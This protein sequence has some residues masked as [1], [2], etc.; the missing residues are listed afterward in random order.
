M[1]KRVKSF[2][3]YLTIECFRVA[4]TGISALGLYGSYGRVRNLSPVQDAVRCLSLK[5]R[6]TKKG[7]LPVTT[8][9]LTDEFSIQTAPLLFLLA[10]SNNFSTEF[11]I[12]NKQSVNKHI[13][14]VSCLTKDFCI[15]HC[16][17]DSCKF[18]FFFYINNK[19]ASYSGT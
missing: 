13:C 9:T 14:S 15:K 11:S 18:M 10:F 4:Q 16:L 8:L 17:N 3:V 12:S 5:K 1:N 6:K 19:N 7:S 2:L